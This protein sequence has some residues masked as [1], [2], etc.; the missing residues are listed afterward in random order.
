[1]EDCLQA[2]QEALRFCPSDLFLQRGAQLLGGTSAPP[3]LVK[4][5]RNLCRGKIFTV[6]YL[7][8]K[9]YF[10]NALTLHR[11]TQEASI[12]TI[13][14]VR[15]CVERPGVASEKSRKTATSFTPSRHIYLPFCS[16]YACIRPTCTAPT[17]TK[18]DSSCSFRPRPRTSQGKKKQ[19]L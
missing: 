8:E 17:H 6:H 11:S 10:A 19:Q 5:F 15:T 18:D 2:F 12:C 4:Q 3:P 14:D 1:M 7:R 13:G 9:K 16:A